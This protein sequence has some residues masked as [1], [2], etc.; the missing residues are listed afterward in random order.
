M[1]IEKKNKKNFHEDITV[2]RYQE[3]ESIGSVS[4]RTEHASHLD[5]PLSIHQETQNSQQSFRSTPT[6]SNHLSG[7]VSVRTNSQFEIDDMEKEHATNQTVKKTYQ[8]S[9]MHNP[10]KVTERKRQVHVSTSILQEGESEHEPEPRNESPEK[11]EQKATTKR[12]EH[13][14]LGSENS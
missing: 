12:V 2:T 13:N 14:S 1:S 6:A 3:Q 4:Q 10:C 9:T 5:V 7:N 8:I 11:T